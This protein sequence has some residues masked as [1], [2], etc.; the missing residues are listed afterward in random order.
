MNAEMTEININ[1]W[2]EYGN[3]GT[4]KTYVKNDDITVILKLFKEEGAVKLAEQ[5]FKNTNAI[6]NLGI[7]CPGAISLATDGKRYGVIAERLNDKKSFSRMIS[8]DMSCMDEISRKFA[9]HA[10]ELHN[11][12]CD[13]AVFTSH[14]DYYRRLINESSFYSKKLKSR[15]QS[16]VD[17]LESTTTCLHGDLTINNIVSA[18]GKD[19]WIDLGDFG[20][21]D[22]YLDLGRHGI[23]NR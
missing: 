2:Q 17:E 21:G 11:T 7:S 4:A 16:Y 3:G 22:P 6:S 8:E 15:L 10:H 1:E 23:P 18:A 9:S 20:Y 13:T 5:E 12:Q 14:A 19:Y